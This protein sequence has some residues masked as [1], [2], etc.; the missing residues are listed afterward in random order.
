MSTLEKFFG[1]RLD[2]NESNFNAINHFFSVWHFVALFLIAGGIVLIS[3]IAKKKNSDWHNKMFKVIAFIFLGLEILRIIYRSV[4]YYC[5]ETYLPENTN[6]YNWAEIISFAL[7]TMITFFTIITL[8]LNNEKWNKYA[9]D[10]IFV[11]ALLGGVSALVYPDMLNTYYPIYHIMN[12]QTLITHGLLVATPILLIVT[13]RYTPNIKNSWKPL[14]QMV[15]FAIIARIFSVISGS[16]FM[17]MNG[18]EL[19][20]AYANKPVYSYA[21]L[22]AIAFSI[23]TVLCYLPFVIANAKKKN[24]K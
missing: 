11:I 6:I 17:Y 18:F 16:S 23:W 22:L 20:P 14:L 4:I 10:V 3:L 1:W 21:W 8:L 7:C 19:I 9:Y 15:F 2:S 24:S 5:Y 13:K 12:I